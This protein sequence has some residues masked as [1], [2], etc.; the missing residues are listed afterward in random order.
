MSREIK[1]RARK[2]TIHNAGKTYECKTYEWVHYEPMDGLP[3]MKENETIVHGQVDL[4]Y[5]GLKDKN[6]VEIYKGDIIVNKTGRTCKVV[7]HEWT[8]QWDA[9]IIGKAIG[10]ES[11]FACVNWKYVKIIGN[12]H[13]NPELLC[14]A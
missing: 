8:G 11:D 1:F 4:Q 13:S 9:K 12:I 14:S 7:W 10:D 2:R 5:T 3:K 6:G